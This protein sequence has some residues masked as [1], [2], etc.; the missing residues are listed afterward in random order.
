MLRDRRTRSI[1]FLVVSMLIMLATF[2]LLLSSS[3]SGL[4]SVPTP[5]PTVQGIFLYIGVNTQL[6]PY[7]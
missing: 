3:N 2:V 4:R 6:V 5:T 7:A 1:V